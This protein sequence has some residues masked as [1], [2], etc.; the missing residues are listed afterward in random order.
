MNTPNYEHHCDQDP[1]NSAA[2]IPVALNAASTT[3][4]VTPEPQ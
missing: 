4:A 2:S 3:D 1:G